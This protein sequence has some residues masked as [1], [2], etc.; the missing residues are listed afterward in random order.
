MRDFTVSAYCSLLNALKSHSSAFCGFED[1]VT[2]E[3][4]AF[5]ILRHDVDRKPGYALILA[6]AEADSGIKGSY[7]FRLP[8][9]RLQENVIREIAGLGH[10]IAYHYEDLS[11][12]CRRLFHA[13]HRVDEETARQAYDRFR[14]NLCYLRKLAGVNVISMHGSP[15]STVDNRL[16]WKYYDY[17]ES[18][19]VCEPYFDIDV[20][21]VLYLTDTGRRWDAERSNIRDRGY[22]HA[23]ETGTGESAG[24]K[25]RPLSG[26][27]M[28]MT[29]EGIA[30]RSR[31]RV[32]STADLVRLA[33]N[34]M[35]PPKVII[36]THPQRWTD[37]PL[38]WIN[39][40][41]NQSIKNQLKK[42]IA[43]SKF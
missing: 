1:A 8:G 40:L 14:E 18:G 35:L 19:I 22:A 10:E 27:L 25:T 43:S 30:F 9:S 28:S 31:F 6:H 37:K 33:E 29:P 17:R 41:V 4:E 32:H 7:H 15:L 36:N 42:L 38:P 24:W 3:Q 5:I 16:L 2:G 23:S 34:G 11:A 39:E 13:R 12:L 21:D 20:S 26:S